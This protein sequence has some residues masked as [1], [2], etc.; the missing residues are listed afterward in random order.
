MQPSDLVSFQCMTSTE[1]CC[2]QGGC[3]SILQRDLGSREFDAT[4][5]EYHLFIARKHLH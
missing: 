5:V 3:R 1:H 2:K 4:N